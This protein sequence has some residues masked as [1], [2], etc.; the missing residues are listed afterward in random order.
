LARLF[1]LELIDTG[2]DQQLRQVVNL[3]VVD[4]LPIREIE[5]P[6]F[7][8][9]AGFERKFD[10]VTAEVV[11]G[12]KAPGIEK[13]CRVGNAFL[14]HFLKV[15]AVHPFFAATPEGGNRISPC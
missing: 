15:E 1:V 13:R 7:S 5:L 12:L 9:D 2:D 8:G 6:D 4:N 3:A 14:G 10:R 11:R